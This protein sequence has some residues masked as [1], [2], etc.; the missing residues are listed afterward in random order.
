MRS[1]RRL[2]VTAVLGWMLAGCTVHTVAPTPTPNIIPRG[3]L[4]TPFTIGRLVAPREEVCS[5]H[6]GLKDLCVERFHDSFES[7]LNALLS[8]YMPSADAAHAVFTAEFQLVEFRHSPASA[9]QDNGMVEVE[10]ALRWQFALRD[11]S[12]EAVVKIAETTVGPVRL[13]HVGAAEKA[14]GAL[15]N[16]TLERI[17]GAMNS[18]P[19]W[20]TPPAS[21]GGS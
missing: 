16:A 8:S 2:A 13:F 4:Q 5:S 17:G 20:A 9:L 14:I 7:G 15:V 21:E 19:I 1:I 18:A 6:E 11:K 3:R 12:G 10:V